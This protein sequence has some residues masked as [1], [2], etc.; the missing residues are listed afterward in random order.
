MGDPRIENL[1]KILVQY[2]TKVKPGDWVWI[3]SNIIAQPLV[4]EVVRH[5]LKAGGRPTLQFSSDDITEIAL[6]EMN[7]DQIQWISPVDKILYEQADVRIVIMAS[8]NTRVLTGVD[9]KK[10]QAFGLARR[11]LF[12]TYMQRSASGSLRWTLTQYPCPAYAQDADMSLRE[13]ED[14]VYAATFADQPDPIQAWIDVEQ[15]QQRLV[16]WLK[17]KQEVVV[18]GPNCDLKLSIA[19]R[20]FINSTATHNVPSGE[21]Y[22]SPLEDSA[23]GSIR[24]TYPAIHLGREVDGIELEFKDGKV[25][26]ARAA[27]NEDYLLAMLDSD[28]GARYL[29]EFAIGT[30]YSIQKFTRSILFDEKI[31]GS[32]HLA[33]GAGFPEI[34][35][36]NESSIHWDMICDMRDNSEIW[37]DG[38]LFYKNGQFVV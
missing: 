20:S 35:G 16:E 14:F 17:G 30:N 21:I 8:S 15:K 28:A 38:E 7:E 36:K 34:G 19:G 33:V 23:N 9:P 5:V 6:Q 3:E 10:M 25:V 24:F 12:N 32:I 29:G 22:T 1:A 11:S 2:S 13:Y 31:G 18:R 37:V 26:N 27:K 4:K